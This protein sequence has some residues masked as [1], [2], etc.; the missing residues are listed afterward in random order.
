MLKISKIYFFSKKKLFVNENEECFGI[1]RNIFNF[2]NVA[3]S[4]INYLA[5][6]R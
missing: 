2:G 3:S 4:F 5:D 6:T 1:F